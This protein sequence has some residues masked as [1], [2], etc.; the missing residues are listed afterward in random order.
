MANPFV[1]VELATTDAD[2][3]KAFYQSLFDWKLQDVEIGPGFTYTMIG[4]GEGT[5]G[6]LMKHP[7]PGAPS[8]WLPYVLVEDVGAAAAKAKSLGASVVKDVTEVPNTGSFAIIIDPTG[9]ALG[10]WQPKA[11]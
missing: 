3:A 6:G 10:L 2:A 11:R 4:V 8:A 7:I 9:A 1:H 5:G